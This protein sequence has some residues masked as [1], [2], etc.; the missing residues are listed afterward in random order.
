MYFLCLVILQN[1]VIIESCDF[2]AKSPKS[3]VIILLTY[4]G[5]DMHCKNGNEIFFN[6]SLDPL[7]FL[8]LTD[9]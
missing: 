8:N 6:L 3:Y 9:I 5:S 4:I 7:K 1:Q 2:M